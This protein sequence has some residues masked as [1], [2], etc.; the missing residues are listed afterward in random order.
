MGELVKRMCVEWGQEMHRFS[1]CCRGEGLDLQDAGLP[2]LCSLWICLLPFFLVANI[3]FLR[4]IR[5][6]LFLF[7]VAI[8]TSSAIIMFF[9]FFLFFQVGQSVLA[10]ATEI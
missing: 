4:N 5:N 1:L 3:P 10:E 7:L 2:L 6:V 9:Y 8:F